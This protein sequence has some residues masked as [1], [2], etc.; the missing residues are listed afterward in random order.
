[1]KILFNEPPIISYSPNLQEHKT[2][3]DEGYASLLEYKNGAIVLLFQN[4][5]DHIDGNGLAIFWLVQGEGTFHYEN[6]SIYLKIGDIILFDDQL[7]HGFSSNEICIAV[8][9]DISKE[10]NNDIELIKSKINFF[11]KIPKGN[12][13]KI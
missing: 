4:V 5:D 3:I 9:F 10:L 13:L 2:T 1:M 12:K 7:E 6:T 11:N 8:N